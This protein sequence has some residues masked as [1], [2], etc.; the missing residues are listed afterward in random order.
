LAERRGRV[1]KTAVLRETQAGEHRVAMTPDVVRRLS[2]LGAEVIVESQAGL[3]AGFGDPLYSDAGASVVAGREAVLSQADLVLRIGKPVPDDIALL[4]QGAIHVSFLDPFNE[5]GLIDALCKSGVT[6]ISME[7]IPRTTRAQKMD[8][9]SSQGSLAG[10]VM[11]LK[12][13]MA[14]PNIMP[15]MT[16]PAGTI[17]P[18]TVFVIGAGVAGLQAIATARRLGSRVIAFDTRPET[19]EQVRSLGAKFLE[20]DLGE[21]QSTKDGYAVQLS[22]EQLERQKQGQA[23]QVTASDIVIT[24]AQVFGRK[25]PVLITVDMVASMRAGSV[26]V[27]MAAETGGNVEGSVPGQ[28]VTVGGV[29]IVGDGNW[30]AAVPRDA[31][32]MYASN[33]G[34]M[35]EEFWDKE[36]KRMTI[37]FADD[38]IKGCVITHDGRIV[39]E[40]ISKLRTAGE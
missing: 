22:A 14:A 35:V 17:R 33:L 8:A 38:I 24:T 27:D 26:V 1:M 16:T 9:L 11:M 2:G 29:T 20:I 13:A 18:A 3:A 4:K 5:H 28:T 10:Y 36:A 31:S 30:A 21:T 12:A 19:A 25:P 39:N 15:M 6:A 23:K 7:M 37:D 32:Q 34:A 40:T